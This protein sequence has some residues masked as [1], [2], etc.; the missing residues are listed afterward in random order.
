MTIADINIII[1]DI[2]AGKGEDR[3]DVNGDGE[4]T[5]ADINFVIDVILGLK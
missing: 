5:V 2:L 4:V 3:C 1:D